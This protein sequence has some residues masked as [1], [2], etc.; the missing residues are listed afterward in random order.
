MHHFFQCTVTRS[1][2]R[3]RAVI[4]VRA[5]Y[6]NRKVTYPSMLFIYGFA[7]VAGVL[8]VLVSAYI[9]VLN[10]YLRQDDAAASSAPSSAS[11]APAV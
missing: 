5:K 1:V 4:G 10:Y 2:Q 11:R 7:I 8:V 9:L 6:L 3:G